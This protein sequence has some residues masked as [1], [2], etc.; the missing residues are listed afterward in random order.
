MSSARVV[1][2]QRGNSSAFP[3]LPL[4]SL[5]HVRFQRQCT[6]T[7]CIGSPRI[8]VRRITEAAS[9]SVTHPLD[10]RCSA[11]VEHR[12]G[13]V[14]RRHDVAMAMRSDAVSVTRHR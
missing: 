14:E 2:S 10:E 8:P 5:Q 12:A 3:E 7:M 1:L 4:S 11:A 13:R 9:P 6:I